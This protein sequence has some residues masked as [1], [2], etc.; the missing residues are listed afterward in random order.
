LFIGCYAF[1]PG[2]EL[3]R[4]SVAFAVAMLVG[5]LLLAG[6]LVWRRRTA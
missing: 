3:A 2:S 6:G 1:A 5:L 4:I